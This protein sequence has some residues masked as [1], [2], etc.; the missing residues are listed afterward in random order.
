[1]DSPLKPFRFPG[2]EAHI[3][4]VDQDIGQFRYQIA[5]IRGA[6]AED[7][8]MAS[9]W[10]QAVR[11]RDE[12]SVVFLPYLPGARADRGVPDLH[13]YTSLVAEITA[14]QM[15]YLDPH[16]PVWVND[17]QDM[18]DIAVMTEFPFERIIRREI[19]DATSDIRPMPYTGVIAPDKGAVERA[20]RAAH[21]MGVPVYKAGKTRDFETG[22]LTGFH[23]EDELPSGNFLIVDDICDGGGTFVGLGEEILQSSEDISLSLWVTHGIFSKGT[24]FLYSIFDHIYTTNSHPGSV[25]AHNDQR[26]TVIDVTPYLIESINV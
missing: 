25:E 14:D 11:A 26:A 7:L 3:K 18:D 19:Q 9:M 24:G 6:S 22:K 21:V 10:G 12:K 8:V 5:D 2:G 1:M 15:V 20:T 23:M 4:D 16:S 17:Y 13:T